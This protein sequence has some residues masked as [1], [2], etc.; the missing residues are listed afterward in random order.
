M[1]KVLLLLLATVSLIS[2]TK[3]DLNSCNCGEFNVVF[4]P[5]YSQFYVI[6]LAGCGGWEFETESEWREAIGE[7]PVG[8]NVIMCLPLE[9]KSYDI[10]LSE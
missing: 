8:Q 9:D 4:T 6:E 2:C 10:L 1:K 5:P 7:S 3:V